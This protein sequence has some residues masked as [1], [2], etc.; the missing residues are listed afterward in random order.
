[1][2]ESTHQKKNNEPQSS[3]AAGR[4]ISLVGRRS[5]AMPGPALEQRCP[6]HA[7]NQSYQTAAQGATDWPRRSDTCLKW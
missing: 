6:L 3:S 2:I 5:L 4:Q 1:M 7:T